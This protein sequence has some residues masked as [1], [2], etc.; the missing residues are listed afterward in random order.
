MLRLSWMVYCPRFEYVEIV[1]ATALL[2][3]VMLKLFV[4]D[5]AEFAAMTVNVYTP[6]TVGVP[7]IEPVDES[8]IKPDGRLPEYSDHVIGA[9]PVAESVA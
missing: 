5:P 3:R 8:S 7:E 4:S 1:G 9:S 6:V 2:L